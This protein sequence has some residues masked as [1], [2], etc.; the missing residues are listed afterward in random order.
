MDRRPNYQPEGLGDPLEDVQSFNIVQFLAA[1]QDFGVLDEDLPLNNNYQ[2]PPQMRQLQN[3]V[4]DPQHNT[5]NGMYRLVSSR[6]PDTPPITDVSRNGSSASPSTNSDPPYS[7][8]NFNAYSIINGNAVNNNGL[9]LGVHDLHQN[10]MQQEFMGQLQQPPAQPQRTNHNQINSPQRAA[11]FMSS[12]Q[13]S[14][15]NTPQSMTQTS[16]QQSARSENYSI[17]QYNA[18][19][20]DTLYSM[21]SASSEGSIHSQNSEAPQ[22]RKRPRIESQIEP[23]KFMPAVSA[24][25]MA[26]SPVEGTYQDDEFSHQV[27]KFTKFQEDQWNGLYDTNGRELKQLQVHVVADKGFNH[28]SIDNCFVNQ[29]KNH[30]QISVHVEACDNMPPKNV[31]FNGALV[32]IHEF[33]LSFC[34]VKAEM[35]T[36]EICIKQSRTDRKPHPHNPVPF[37]IQERRMTKVTVPRLH[38]SETTLNNQR[39]NYRPNPDQKY[40]L[41]V[42]RLLACVGDDTTILIQSYASEKVIVRV[43]FH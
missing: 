19:H 23:P 36:S 42:V 32:P 18:Q 41:L 25:P 7:P 9:I 31:R 13:A 26:S 8:D 10:L 3:V 2:H 37:E 15:Q 22:N 4:P 5:S 28:S 43:S 38:F 34:G 6:L 14:Q 11:C 12:Y 35:P 20:M 29:K 40:F 30:F 16:P 33:K 21:L 24:N 17:S 1:D 39:K 27:I